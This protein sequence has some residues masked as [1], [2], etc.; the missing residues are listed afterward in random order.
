M[1]VLSSAFVSCEKS[2]S[3]VPFARKPVLI[4]ETSSTCAINAGYSERL[5]FP[6]GTNATDS[7]F[8]GA[9]DKIPALAQDASWPGCWRSKS[10][11]RIPARDNSSAIEPPIKPP[12]AMA[13]SNFFM[14]ISY[15]IHEH[16]QGVTQMFGRQ[17]GQSWKDRWN[18]KARV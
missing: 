2:A 13:T 7:G 9:G 18:E 10:P 12:P 3:S 6:S 16:A 5:A 8:S 14:G 4:P 1:M 11:T 15:R 17:I